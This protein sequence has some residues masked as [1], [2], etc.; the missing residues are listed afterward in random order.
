LLT[1]HDVGY[2]R[3]CFESHRYSEINMKDNMISNKKTEHVT[4]KKHH[5]QLE[6]SSKACEFRTNCYLCL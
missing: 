6:S 1:L 2:G 5:F 3:Y 4:K